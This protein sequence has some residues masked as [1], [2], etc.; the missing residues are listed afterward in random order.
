MTDLLEYRVAEGVATITMDDGKAN[1][2]SHAMIGAVDAAVDR[3]VSD[4]RALVLAGRDGRFSAGFDLSVMQA[5]PEAARDLVA[6]GGRLC[7]KIYTLPLPVVVA[8][9][10]HALAAGALLL[11][12][13]DWRVGG[14]GDFKIGLNEVSIG[15]PLPQFAID[16]AAARLDVRQLTRATA[17]AHIYDS[18]GAVEAGYLDVL[19]A[20]PLAEATTVAAELAG[21]LSAFGFAGTRRTARQALAD[22]V[23]TGIEADLIHFDLDP[24]A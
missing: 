6:A 15:L 12:S 14:E 8:C 18:A 2:L 9:T 16:L 13:G 1:A 23:L 20:D 24:E 4:A 21:R 3:A 7:M 11:L 5:G 10:G 22:A 19:A 17:L